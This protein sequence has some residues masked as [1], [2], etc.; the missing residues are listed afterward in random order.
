MRL[1]RNFGF[2]GFD[3]VIHPG[4]NGKMIEACAAMGWSN[5]DGID[6]RR[7]GQSAQPSP[8]IERPWPAS[9]ASPCSSY[10]DSERNNYQY[11]VV[12]DRRRRRPSV[13]IAIVEAL[14]AENML[15]RRY[16]WP[17]CHG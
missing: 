7:R 16:F 9:P 11:V 3:N 17:G 13:A 1:M 4:T 8:P 6:A 5:L 12:R 10:D 2:A 15:A 14:H